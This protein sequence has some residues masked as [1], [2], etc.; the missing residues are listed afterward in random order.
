MTLATIIPLATTVPAHAS[1]IPSG[2]IAGVL[3]LC[4]PAVPVPTTLP[5][6]TTVPGSSGTTS[7]TVPP[8]APDRL[9]LT[10]APSYA[11]LLKDGVVV[12]RTSLRVSL[13]KD[14]PTATPYY[15]GQFLIVARFT[16]RAAPGHYLAQALQVRRNVVVT[17][18]RTSHLHVVIA[19]C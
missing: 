15:N 13:V 7:T 14:G 18:G 6:P 9:I 10:P 2:A 1:A 4:V 16:L 19:G 11:V 17:A 3:E 12:S 5:T 8:L